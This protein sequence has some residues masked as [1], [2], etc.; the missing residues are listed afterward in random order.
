[1][2]TAAIRHRQRIPATRQEL[3]AAD[4]LPVRCVCNYDVNPLPQHCCF[5][6]QQYKEQQI[7]VHRG[8][9]LLPQNY[10]PRKRRFHPQNARRPAKH[11]TPFGK[12]RKKRNFRMRYTAD[13]G[14]TSRY[15]IAPRK[16]QQ[17]TQCRRRKHQRRFA[18]HLLSTPIY[19]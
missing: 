5:V 14:R 2:T 4:D 13:G 8:V 16:S 15:Q 7:S 9:P 10:I 1:V 11:K 17:A 19:G 18:A 6:K 3:T 12:M